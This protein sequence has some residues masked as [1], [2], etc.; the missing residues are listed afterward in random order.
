MRVRCLRLLAV[1]SSMIG[2][3]LS[4]LDARAQFPITQSFT[5]ATAAGWT[6]LGSAVL[7]ANGHGDAA[8]AGWL[9]LTD[10]TTNKA[11][12]AYYNTAFPSTY[13]IVATFDYA[14]YGGNHADGF[15][16]FLID[17]ATA[18]PD[19]GS[20]GG[21]LGYA[22][23]VDSTAPNSCATGPQTVLGPAATY[24]GVMHVCPAEY[25]VGSFDA[26]L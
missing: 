16:V 12:T 6:L 14:D 23:K 20:S 21:P 13:G 7:T 3:A 5:G 24:H 18:S 1:V 2:L 25:D 22:A 26:V 4:P 17:G 9:R 11:G 8:G 19:V 15:S 10:A